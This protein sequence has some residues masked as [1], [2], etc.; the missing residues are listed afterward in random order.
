MSET[1][2]L[3]VVIGEC[4]S[5][6]LDH[7]CSKIVICSMDICIIDLKDGTWGSGHVGLVIRKT[8]WRRLG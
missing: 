5:D 2:S 3:T 1:A 8:S 7:L 6:E 4:L